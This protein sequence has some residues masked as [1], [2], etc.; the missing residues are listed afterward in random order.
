MRSINGAWSLERKCVK[1][2]CRWCGIPKEQRVLVTAHDAFG[3]F[4]RQYGMQVIGIQGTSTAA[5]AGAGAVRTI[6][7]TIA[8]RKVKA[9]FVESSVP[10]GTIEALQKAVESRGWNVVIGGQL[11]SDA[12]GQD[13]TPEGTYVGMVRHN[14]DTIVGALK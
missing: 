14:I 6:A 1:K 4:G 2:C 3:Y 10:K 9:I 12:M 8:R 11:F 7:D 13:G 5:E